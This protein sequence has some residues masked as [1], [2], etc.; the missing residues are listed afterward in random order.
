MRKLIL[1][2][3]LFCA[4]S[5][6]HAQDT[7]RKFRQVIYKAMVFNNDKVINNDYL[8][9][10]NDSTIALSQNPQPFGLPSYHAASLHNINY[11][12]IDQIQLKRK[13][14]VGRGILTGVIVGGALGVIT[15]FGSGNDNRS[16]LIQFS[17]GEKAF[18]LGIAGGLAGGIIGGVLGQ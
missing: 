15:G 17:A 18:S 11:S 8:V 2:G 13:G 10:V 6:S 14:A 4:I 1:A 7:T 16:E 3:I 9:Q 5:Q 12:D